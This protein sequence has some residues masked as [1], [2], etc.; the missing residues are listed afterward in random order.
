LIRDVPEDV[1]A[2]IDAKAADSTLRSFLSAKPIH[3]SD[4]APPRRIADVYRR[5]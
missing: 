5:R 2:A 3:G 4:F 1:V